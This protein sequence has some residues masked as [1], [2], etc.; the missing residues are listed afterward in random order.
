MRIITLLLLLLFV[1]Q[2]NAQKVLQ[3]EKYGSAKTKKI[4]IGQEITYKL[5]NDE[6]WYRGVIEDLNV[7]KNWVTLGDR[8]V[9][10]DSIEA[11]R[12][13]I[14]WSKAARTSLY[15]F[16]AAWS[17]NALVGTLTDGNPK[18]NYLW[19]DAIVTG[20]SWLTGWIVPKLFKNKVTKFG[21]KRR[22]R[23]L[24]LN[25][26]PPKPVVKA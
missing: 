18:T 23:M 25:V 17:G 16:G 24:D 11:F 7:E 4:Y 20:V 14:G 19:S 5:K 1:L 10:L 12:R 9:P 21:G 2:L 8:Y 26:L 15:T 22:L 3:I 13:P 6:Y